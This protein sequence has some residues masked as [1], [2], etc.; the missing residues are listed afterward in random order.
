MAGPELKTKDATVLKGHHQQCPKVVRGW[1][2][3]PDA[4]SVLVILQAAL[5]H[6]R[7][8]V[9]GTVARLRN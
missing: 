4:S 7:G 3:S 5:C 6:E 8:R 2:G 9:Q 1:K